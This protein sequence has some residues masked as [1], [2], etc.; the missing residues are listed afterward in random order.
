[1]GEI[2]ITKLKWDST[3]WNIDV[4]EIS[5]DEETL[6][7]KLYL[8]ELNKNSLFVVQA[9]TFDHDI[10][11]IEKLENEGF[12]FVESKINLTK[13]IEEK[14]D[15]Y[16]DNQIRFVDIVDLQR[17]KNKFYSLYGKVSRFSF[18][19]KNK[20]NKFYYTWAAKSI[21]GKLDDNCLGYYN[22]DNLQGFIT[23][24]IAN[25]KLIIGLLGVFP[26]Y[27]GNK[28]SDQLL[29]SVYNIAFMNNCDEILV[30]TQGKNIRAL[31]K[32]IKN[33]FI[34]ESIQHWY[35]LKGGF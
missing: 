24:K 22:D 16:I 30:A 8:K 12:R 10:N 7:N 31:N 21:E 29:N 17:Q 35:Y 13:K 11:G 19:E 34:I 33:N 5:N 20:V 6:E 3:F 4:Y 27:Q 15:T 26:E 2:L 1:M 9:L 14:T 32:Y 18:F 25:N 23:Y 28:I